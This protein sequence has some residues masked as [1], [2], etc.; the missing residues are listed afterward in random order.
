MFL[1]MVQLGPQSVVTAIEQV[2]G[3]LS[4][5]EKI[6]IFEQLDTENHS[7]S[8]L[9]ILRS[10]MHYPNATNIVENLQIQGCFQP[11]KASQYVLMN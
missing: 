7:G 8:R 9:K 5:V 3:D 2:K 4:K 6:N 1:Q 11:L 10:L